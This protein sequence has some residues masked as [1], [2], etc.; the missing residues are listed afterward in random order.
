MV[1]EVT[2]QP[3]PKKARQMQQPQQGVELTVAG[4]WLLQNVEKKIKQ[5]G[6]KNFESEIKLKTAKTCCTEKLEEHVRSTQK[7]AAK[8]LRLQ[9]DWQNYS[10]GRLRFQE[11]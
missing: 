9:Q 11:I 7:R 4:P 2:S 6:C 5:Q 1:V 10:T 8:I 3:R